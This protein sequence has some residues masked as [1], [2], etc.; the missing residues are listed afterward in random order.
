M[1]K[2]KITSFEAGSNNYEKVQQLRPIDDTFFEKLCEDK[3]VCEE[4]IRTIL[5][6]N[7]IVV[8]STAPQ[9]SIKNLQGRSVRVDALCIRGD[10]SYC[11]VEVQRSDNDD[12]LRR[13]RYNA[14]CIT[15]NITDPGVKFEKVPE[16]YVIYISEFDI[17]GAGKTIYHQKTIVEETDET[18]D[19]GLHVVYVN[20]VINDGS[21]TAE[22]MQCFK[23]TQVNNS[24]FPR[25][26][27]RVSYFKTN[28]EGV[29]SMCKIMEEIKNEGIKEGERNSAI[30]MVI[31]L[32]KNGI[33]F[34]IVFNAA[35]QNLTEKEVYQIYQDIQNG[36][37]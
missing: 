25:L 17:M 11:N 35:K 29:A 21:K 5:N 30:N 6:D 34:D 4:I 27:E 10:G 2:N 14:S 1:S 26:S 33:S 28:K 19:D 15:A 18:I 20:T 32:F 24:N 8:E 23:Q 9:K 31:N 7:T 16:L 13:V 22:L 37:I 3:A 36:K 12:H